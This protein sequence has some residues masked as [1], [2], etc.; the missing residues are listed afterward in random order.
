MLSLSRYKNPN[1][2][3]LLSI[4]AEMCVLWTQIESKRELLRLYLRIYPVFSGRTTVEKPLS[5]FFFSLH[6]VPPKPKHKVFQF[7]D[8]VQAKVT[9]NLLPNRK[10]ASQRTKQRGQKYIRHRC[11]AY[12][13]R[14]HLY[15][16][17]V[18]RRKTFVELISS[19]NTKCYYRCY[20]KG[21][22]YNLR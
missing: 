22:F 8:S 4:S 21:A 13:Y 1:A 20:Y 7:F 2:V 19:V 15:M 10:K 9:Q 17:R 3:N 16:D 12:C 6:F 18:N 11:A 5:L 14:I